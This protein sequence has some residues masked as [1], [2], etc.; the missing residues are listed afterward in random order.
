MKN[1]KTLK[2]K[3]FMEL[4]VL[5]EQFIKYLMQN[6]QYS[7]AEAEK[8]LDNIAQGCNT[9][10]DKYHRLV[11]WCY[12]PSVASSLKTI[13]Q[14]LLQIHQQFFQQRIVQSQK[15][16]ADLNNDLLAQQ[17]QLTQQYQLELTTLESQISMEA[18][19]LT[20][21]RAKAQ[22]IEQLPNIKSLTHAQFQ[23]I[24][25]TI[26]AHA[27][28]LKIQE[29]LP[30]PERVTVASI[31]PK[32]IPTAKQANQKNTLD[33]LRQKMELYEQQLK[34]ESMGKR[35]RMLFSPERWRR[36]S[37][38]REYKKQV[39]NNQDQE[40][41]YQAAETWCNKFA[42]GNNKNSRFHNIC[43]QPVAESL[44]QDYFDDYSDIK[45]KNRQ[46]VIMHHLQL[47]HTMVAHEKNVVKL[48]DE[49]D[50]QRSIISPL[51]QALIAYKS[52]VTSMQE[53]AFGYIASDADEVIQN[54][55]KIKQ[56][57]FDMDHTLRVN[58][59]K[60]IVDD[61]A[62]L[63]RH[64]EIDTLAQLKLTERMQ[65]LV[66]DPK[67]Q[68]IIFKY[69]DHLLENMR[70]Y[71]GLASNKDYLGTKQISF[72]INLIGSTEQIAI[73]KKLQL[74]I[75]TRNQKTI[76]A[77]VSQSAESYAK[78]LASHLQ[79]QEFYKTLDRWLP[80]YEKH[81]E[82]NSLPEKQ[83]DKLIYKEIVQCKKNAKQFHKADNNHL[84]T[85][86]NQVMEANY[87]AS[88]QNQQNHSS[89]NSYENMSS[90]RAH[91]FVS[92][93]GSSQQK[94]RWNRRLY[95]AIQ[96]KLDKSH[97]PAPQLSA[98]IEMKMH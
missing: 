79:S 17:K 50:K 65:E 46:L 21:L 19:L 42:M 56:L 15:R 20:D 25:K 93:F 55:A 3:F 26:V 58:K 76:S 16:H 45:D 77:F 35:F 57:C 75:K 90:K 34:K 41:A 12:E 6:H 22:T 10:G 36:R 52:S 38:I 63:T 88:L 49:F 85:I 86:V 92:I 66:G 54:V 40:R 9:S 94:Q 70:T 37:A 82:Q 8:F 14:S 91:L 87:R 23:S 74:E 89:S 1:N 67:A 33:L 47:D 5:R 72:I 11:T 96:M 78:S 53:T 13:Q 73:L 97:L 62:V 83:E 59:A 27:N 32:A 30:I 18:K 48:T 71:G 80:V 84:A 60:S 68:N 95:P 51:H 43:L 61:I 7:Q 24:A 29:K 98:A 39:L 2:D 4:E 31:D 69:L 81:I 44:S 64:V 28:K